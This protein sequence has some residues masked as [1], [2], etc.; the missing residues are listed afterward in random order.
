MGDIGQAHNAA[1]GIFRILDTKDEY[2]LQE[3]KV[4]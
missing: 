4:P 3:E 1:K 2:Q